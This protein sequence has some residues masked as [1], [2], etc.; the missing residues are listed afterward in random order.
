MKHYTDVALLACK[1]VSHGLSIAKSSSQLQCSAVCLLLRGG[2]A[3]SQHGHALFKF[4]PTRLL[5]VLAILQACQLRSIRRA[6]ED[7]S[8]WRDE[9]FLRFRLYPSL[10]ADELQRMTNTPMGAAVG[11]EEVRDEGRGKRWCGCGS[12]DF[13]VSLDVERPTVWGCGAGA[14]DGP[15]G[16]DRGALPHVTG[17]L[18]LGESRGERCKGEMVQG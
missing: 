2:R 12:R 17:R 3:E 4:S 16:G 13:P 6:G 8:G 15:D 14:G 9:A 11:I 1:G 5:S 10:S 7:G 18:G